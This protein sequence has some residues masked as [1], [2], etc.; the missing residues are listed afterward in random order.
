MLNKKLTREQAISDLVDNDINDIVNGNLHGDNSYI[1]D[2]MCCG[3][4]GYDNFTDTELIDEYKE[5]LI[6]EI[7]LI[8][9]ETPVNVP[10]TE[11]QFNQAKD[12]LIAKF[13]ESVKA[14]TESDIIRRTIAMNWWN[15]LSPTSK[16]MHT[17][18]KYDGRTSDSL[19]GREIEAMYIEAMYFNFNND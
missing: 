12:I 18:C 17:T 8:P 4:K 10:V 15:K 1:N 2:I 3:F 5:T 9:D 7:E 14:K 13:E 19:T 16:D 11:E 6:W